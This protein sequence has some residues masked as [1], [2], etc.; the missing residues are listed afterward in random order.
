MKHNKGFTLVE[1]LVTILAASV[2]TAAALSILLLGMRVHQKTSSPA[3]NQS[4]I[5]LGISILEDLAAESV[6]TEATPMF[7]RTKNGENLFTYNPTNDTVFLGSYGGTPILTNV[8]A[9]DA[10]YDN[11]KQLLVLT[12]EI[13]NNQYTSKVYSRT[14]PSSTVPTESIPEESGGSNDDTNNNIE[15]E[16]AASAAASS[17][18]SPKSLSDIAKFNALDRQIFLEIL[19]AEEGSTGKASSGEY[20]SEWYIGSYQ[21]NPGWDPDTPW[22]ACFLSWALDQ[23]RTSLEEVPRYAHVDKFLEFFDESHWKTENPQPGDIIFFDWI[24]NDVTAPQHV[25]VV[26]STDGEF[27]YTIEGNNEGK[28]ASCSYRLDDARILGY[29]VLSWK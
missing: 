1:M 13:G 23:C 24:V 15:V 27:V 16:A 29:G 7:V 18:A 6:I 25:G 14:D 4:S 17:Y 28:V 5:S 2:I 20:F 9:F 22:C 8:T 21:D 12:L 26:V 19:T 10:S 3:A 11:T